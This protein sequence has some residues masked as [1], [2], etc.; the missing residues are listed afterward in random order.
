MASM[1]SVRH[2]SLGGSTGNAILTSATASVLAVLLIAEGITILRMGS[3][4]SAHMFIGL[5]LIPP[6][7][8][9]LASTGYRFVRYYSGA[10]SYREKGPPLLPLRLLAPVLVASTVAVFSTG[11]WLLLLGHKSDQV[12]LL[13]Q[14]FFFI[15][16][17]VFGIHFLAHLPHALR[18]LRVDWAPDAPPRGPGCRRS[19]PARR[20]VHR[21]RSGPGVG[22]LERDQRLARRLGRLTP[23]ARSDA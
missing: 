10:P 19:R 21:V 7:L 23:A 20:R 4:L 3:L 15:W 13:H 17:A 5:A 8:L 18:S 9:K 12:L 6:V 16:G 14:V 2:P 11:I 22:P 1:R